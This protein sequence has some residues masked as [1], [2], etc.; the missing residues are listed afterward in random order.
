M[1]LR[2]TLLLGPYTS[3]HEFEEE[4][5]DVESLGDSGLK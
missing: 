5:D 4:D 3:E 2:V 1:N